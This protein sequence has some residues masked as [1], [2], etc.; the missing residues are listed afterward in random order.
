MR[1][2]TRWGVVAAICALTAACGSGQ[3]STPQARGEIEFGIWAWDAAEIP[4]FVPTNDVPNIEDQPYGWRIQLKESDQ[5]ITWTEVLTLPKAPLSWG[6]TA[7]NP[8]ITISNDG[9]TATT[10]GESAPTDGFIDNIW[11]VAAG[12]PPGIYEISVKIDGDNSAVFRFRLGEPIVAPE[13]PET[14]VTI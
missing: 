8:N 3:Q 6:G 11:S 9:R 5:P 7:D 14:K 10:N 12:D 4:H 2:K 1:V 13:D